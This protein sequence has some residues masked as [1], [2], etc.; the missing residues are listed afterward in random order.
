[1]RPQAMW[2]ALFLLNAAGA[3]ANFR[4]APEAQLPILWNCMAFACTTGMFA[5]LFK[6]VRH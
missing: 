3:V 4:V 2:T 5:C 6:L 1:M